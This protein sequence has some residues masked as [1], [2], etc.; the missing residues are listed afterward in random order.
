MSSNPGL[1]PIDASS[2][3]SP[4]KL[5][6]PKMSLDINKWPLVGQPLLLPSWELR[7]QRSGFWSIY[8]LIQFSR[9]VFLYLWFFFNLHFIF[10]LKTVVI[11]K[12]ISF[13]TFYEYGCN[14]IISQGIISLNDVHSKTFKMLLDFNSKRPLK[15]KYVWK[16]TL[17]HLCNEI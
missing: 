17:W 6:Q 14:Y 2:T 10:S 8:L 1:Y 12:W 15:R 11:L 5:W 4:S 16:N 13:I 3:C 9:Y 7:S